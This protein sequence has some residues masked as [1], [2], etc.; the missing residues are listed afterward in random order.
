MHKT[1]QPTDA[2]KI[3]ILAQHPKSLRTADLD[4]WTVNIAMLNCFLIVNV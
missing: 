3:A 4:E 2:D 1:V